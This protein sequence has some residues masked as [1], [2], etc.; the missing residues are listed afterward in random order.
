MP[1]RV[2]TRSPAR[3]RRAGLVVGVAYLATL[4]VNRSLV[5]VQ[6]PSMEPALW[7]GDRLVTVPAH[8]WWL[9]P[10]QVVVVIPPDGPARVVKRLHGLERAAGAGHA[11]DRSARWL[12]DVRGDAVDR[13]TD[14]RWWGPVPVRHIRRV[15][16]ARWP[17]LRT[18]LRRPPADERTS[19]RTDGRG[20]PGPG[21]RAWTSSSGSSSATSPS[22]RRP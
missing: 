3:W 10:G 2:V 18:R 6:G 1:T 11:R 4:A 14:S 9:R 15:A 22:L 17:D 7:P 20:Q 19:Q 16:I 13:S 12:A 5:V 21:R 8:W